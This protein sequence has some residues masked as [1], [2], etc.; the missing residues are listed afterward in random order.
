MAFH[1]HTWRVTALRVVKT[2]LLLG[3]MLAGAVVGTVRVAWR[4]SAD[5]Y[6]PLEER[7]KGL[8]TTKKGTA[9]QTTILAVKEIGTIS[10]E[11][12]TTM[13]FHEG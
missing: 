5:D 13:S 1:I 3:M 10:N 9:S 4:A 6:T 8:Y 7:K 12:E 2:F 11:L